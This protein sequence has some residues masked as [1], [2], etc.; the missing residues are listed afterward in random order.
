MLRD[1][2]KFK[3]LFIDK[4]QTMYGIGM[5]ESSDVE[6]YIAL[7]S[8]IKDHIYR[9]WVYTNKKYDE[10]NAKQMYYFSI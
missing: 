8:M 10:V 5:E 7:S 4:V 9:N 2:E 6:K 1:K 3:Y